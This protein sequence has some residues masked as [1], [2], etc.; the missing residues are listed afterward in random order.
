MKQLLENNDVK[1]LP[2]AKVAVFVGNS[3]DP[4]PGHETPWI[5]IAYQLAGKAGVE[6]LGSNAGSKASGTTALKT[7][8][9]TAG[10]SVVILMDEVLNYI[11]RYSDD[12]ESFRDFLEIASIIRDSEIGFYRN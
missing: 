5:D 12:A 8:F 1:I 10:G 7:L 6:S 9:A 3:W 4:Q 2:K 11:S